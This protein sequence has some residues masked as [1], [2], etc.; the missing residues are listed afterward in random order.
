MNMRMFG[1]D[2]ERREYITRMRNVLS[3][4]ATKRRRSKPGYEATG[5]D[6]ERAVR[7]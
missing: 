4:R 6:N 2:L 1:E 5:G 3:R 7:T